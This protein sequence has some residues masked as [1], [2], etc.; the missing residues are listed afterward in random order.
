MEQGL[1]PLRA[2]GWLPALTVALTPF[3]PLPQSVSSSP[4]ESLQDEERTGL[5][6]KR[7]EKELP[8]HSVSAPRAGAGRAGLGRGLGSP[9]PTL[10]HRDAVL[11]ARTKRMRSPREAPQTKAGSLPT[12]LA[13]IGPGR[14]VQEKMGPGSDVLGKMGHSG[15]EHRAFSSISL[16]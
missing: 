15:A 14:D 16:S 8:G 5:K 9:V 10:L 1:A 4:A 11:G 12:E 7:E 3:F 6:R 13:G 2:E